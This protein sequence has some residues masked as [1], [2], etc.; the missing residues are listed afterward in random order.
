MFFNV[1]KTLP[2]PLSTGEGTGE[3]SSCFYKDKDT[4]SVAPNINLFSKH[5][6]SAL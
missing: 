2:C 6:S 3:E 4:L 1:K 5:L